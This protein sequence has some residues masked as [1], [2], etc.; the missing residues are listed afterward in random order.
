MQITNYLNMDFLIEKL[1]FRVCVRSAWK[2]WEL[3]FEHTGSNIFFVG[4]R[5]EEGDPE[6]DQK[7]AFLDQFET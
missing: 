6:L 5:K 4:R 1:S 3:F 7:T 2:S